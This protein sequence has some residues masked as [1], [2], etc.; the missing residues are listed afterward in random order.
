MAER[1]YVITIKN[2]TDEDASRQTTAPTPDGGGTGQ[3]SKSDEEKNFKFTKGTAFKAFAINTAKKAFSTQINTIALRTGY[4]E[5]QQEMQFA[6]S[7]VNR[8]ATM[9]GAIGIGA[10]TG[11]LGMA[12]IGSALF[13]ANDAVNYFQRKQEIEYA[14]AVEN[15]SIFLNQIRMGAGSNREGKTR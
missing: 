12:L 1:Q 14:R 8:G 10:M 5:K 9:L 2:E 13:I 11:N 3:G 15:N 6:Y 7:A 4:E